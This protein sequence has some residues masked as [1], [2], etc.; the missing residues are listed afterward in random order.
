[1]KRNFAI[2]GERFALATLGLKG[3]KTVLSGRFIWPFCPM[4]RTAPWDFFQRLALIS[5]LPVEFVII[6]CVVLVWF[7]G[8]SNRT[9]FQ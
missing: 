4:P 1:M 5:H 2:I 7:V 9:A 6:H 8:T 3:L